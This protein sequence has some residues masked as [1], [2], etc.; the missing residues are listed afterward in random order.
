MPESNAMKT[1][2]SSNWLKL[3]GI[4]ALTAGGY[5]VL[6]DQ[7]GENK[8]DIE[9]HSMELDGIKTNQIVFASDLED[10]TDDIGDIE[11]SMGS[12]EEKTDENHDL[13]IR[14]GQELG[15]E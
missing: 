14:V 7:V 6:Q 11:E 4:L 1:W 10:L 8:D 3:A 12:I 15:V 13:L 5:A 9:K 2:I